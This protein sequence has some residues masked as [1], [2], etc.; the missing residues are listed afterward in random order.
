MDSWGKTTAFSLLDFL[1]PQRGS[2]RQIL[3][4]AVSLTVD[5]PI[6]ARDEEAFYRLLS[7][8]VETAHT[9]LMTVVLPEE[10]KGFRFGSDRDD[11]PSVPTAVA[12]M[13]YHA[14]WF[15]LMAARF[16]LH[17]SSDKE[18][19]EGCRRALSQVINW[20]HGRTELSGDVRSEVLQVIA[21]HTCVNPVLPHRLRIVSVA[22]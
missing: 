19:R 9:V 17:L 20:T 1:V 15:W 10:R 2:S 22:G 12:S 3:Q 7:H 13:G 14:T 18:E 11:L 16:A 4:R 6:C 8:A 5:M 21:R